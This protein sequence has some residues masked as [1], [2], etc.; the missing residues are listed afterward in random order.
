MRILSLGLAISLIGWLA[1]AQEPAAPAPAAPAAE[2]PRALLLPPKP[3]AH[4]QRVLESASDVARDMSETFAFLEAGQSYYKAFSKGSHT[5][6]ENKAFVKFLEDYER[7]LET[8]RK[9]FGLLKSWF[10][11]SSDLKRE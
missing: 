4:A 5:V 8:A 9:E 10:A 11:N 6:E 1:L 2:S 7:E 3:P